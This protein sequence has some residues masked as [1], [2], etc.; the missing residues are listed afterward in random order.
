MDSSPEIDD[1]F[2]GFWGYKR[3]TSE[4]LQKKLEEIEGETDVFSPGDYLYHLL[5]GDGSGHEDC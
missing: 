1:Y 3:V 5:Y 2:Q 4:Y